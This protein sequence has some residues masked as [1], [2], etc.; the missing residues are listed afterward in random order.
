MEVATG[1]HQLNI[2]NYSQTKL[3]GVGMHFASAPF[4]IGGCTWA[5]H[6]Y[7]GGAKKFHESYISLGVSLCHGP[8]TANVLFK[9]TLLDCNET[10]LKD[11]K[12][13]FFS[14]TFS[15][16]D[17][18]AVKFMK[19][20]MFEAS[21]YLK[22]DSFIIHCMVTVLKYSQTRGTDIARS[23]IEPQCE[24]RQQLGHLLATGLGSDI[25]FEVDGQTFR[26]HKLVLA[27]SSSVFR[28]QF[29]GPMTGKDMNRVRIEEIEA[30]VFKAMLNFIYTDMISDDASS[31]EESW[32]KHQQLLVVADRFRLD[33]MKL[34]CEFLLC[35]D[36]DVERLSSALVL[37]EQHN[38]KQLKAA[39]LKYI[40]S[41]RILIPVMATDGFKHLIASCPWMLQEINASYSHETTNDEIRFG[42]S[43]LLLAL[44]VL[45]IVAMYFALLIGKI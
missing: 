2:T 20:E 10:P 15:L 3:I 9:F 34:T 38:C 33:R 8:K 30:T 31:S 21:D 11:A 44:C 19:K 35:R 37:A 13:K 23:I 25:T 12:S 26:A 16:S 18:W 22:G 45:W 41:Q 28:D 39:S 1:S 7:P 14:E 42:L 43:T 4:S 40:T 36:L 32:W 5:I 24:L 27:A 17:V 6:Y 29:F